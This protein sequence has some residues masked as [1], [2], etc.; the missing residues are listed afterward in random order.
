MKAKVEIRSARKEKVRLAS[1]LQPGMKVC[2]VFPHG[3]GDVVMFR[4]VLEKLKREYPHTTIHMMTK[5]DFG[6][7]D[8]HDEDLEYDLAFWIEYYCTT[9]ANPTITKN[10]LCC[11]TELGI[12]PPIT[13]RPSAPTGFK[14]PWVGIGCTSICCSN[15]N[16]PSVFEAKQLNKGV[17]DAG[18]IPVDTAMVS[19]GYVFEGESYMA[20]SLRG[21]EGTYEKLA[22]VIERCFAFIGTISGAYHVAQAIMPERTLMLCPRAGEWQ[23]L[24]RFAPPH[25]NI[26]DITA[27]KI[28]EW[29]QSLPEK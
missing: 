7:L 29:L 16:T 21:V 24:Y 15:Q 12:S 5:P 26:R 19:S 14:S 18:F 28:T 1:L 23:R 25:I 13:D 4:P 20:C 8:D 2:V 3:M 10:M 11:I 6:P 22:G 27:E 9:A 17:L